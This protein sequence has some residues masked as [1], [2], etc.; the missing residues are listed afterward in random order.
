MQV[1]FFSPE[2]IASPLAGL[3]GN[4]V[5]ETT[6]GM[7]TDRAIDQVT[8]STKENIGKAKEVAK[9][10]KDKIGDGV[11]KAKSMASDRT[12]AMKNGAKDLPEKAGNKVDEAID[13]VK[14]F[15]GK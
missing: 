10:V 3:F 12:N 14:E 4:K 2:A 7:K 11:D 6:Q 1:T 5:S 13:S 8:D 9:D 15:L